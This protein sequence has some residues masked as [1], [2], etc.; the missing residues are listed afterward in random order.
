M[1]RAPR[2]A[3]GRPGQAFL[4]IIDYA[5]GDSF[6]LWFF[7]ASWLG[8]PATG[9]GWVGDHRSARSIRGDPLLRLLA[10]SRFLLY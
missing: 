9:R 5:R 7:W 3:A 10:E 8:Q 2:T 6:S 1:Q 4:V